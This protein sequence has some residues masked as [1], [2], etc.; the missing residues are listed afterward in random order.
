MISLSQWERRSM[1]WIIDLSKASLQCKNDP[2]IN[3]VPLKIWTHSY[4]S[5]MYTV[6]GKVNSMWSRCMPGWLHRYLYSLPWSVDWG[7]LLLPHT[8]YCSQH[9]LKINIT[10]IILI[11]WLLLLAKQEENLKYG[12]LCTQ[13]SLTQFPRH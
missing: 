2:W 4:M 10:W 3:G 9:N 5:T 6:P 1:T 12:V 13:A 8:P 7:W 11:L